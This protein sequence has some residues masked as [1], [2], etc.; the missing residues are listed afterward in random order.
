[1]GQHTLANGHLRPACHIIL[2]LPLWELLVASV[3]DPLLEAGFNGCT[4][5]C[6]RYPRLPLGDS[7]VLL[8]EVWINFERG[9]GIWLVLVHELRGCMCTKGRRSVH[10]GYWG[11]GQVFSECISL[12]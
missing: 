2:T 3:R 8:T 1:M 10:I 5:R 11:R 6:I 9:L 4:F 12:L 7:E